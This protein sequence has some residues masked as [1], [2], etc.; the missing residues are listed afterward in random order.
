MTTIDEILRKRIRIDVLNAF[1]ETYFDYPEKDVEQEIDN[2]LENF[3]IDLYEKHT[4]K[5]NTME[6][7]L[8]SLTKDD[9]IS[10]FRKLYTHWT[11]TEVNEEVEKRLRSLLSDLYQAYKKGTLDAGTKMQS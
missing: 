4:E 3:L 6:E 1:S 7:Y 8:K 10:D 11:D 9:V 2:R 5:E